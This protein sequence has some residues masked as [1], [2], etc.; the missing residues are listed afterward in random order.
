[1][2]SLQNDSFEL[3][4]DKNY[5]VYTVCR[6]NHFILNKMFEWILCC[7]ILLVVS[8]VLLVLLVL[9]FH[10]EELNHLNC[11]LWHELLRLYSIWNYIHC[12][13]SVIIVSP[14]LEFHVE[15][16]IKWMEWNGLNEMVNSVSAQLC[17]L[18]QPCDC[19]C[20][21]KYISTF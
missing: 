8:W 12:I 11:S 13:I 17:Y 18:C 15:S 16:W 19:D 1:M 6:F 5:W 20:Q 9:C 21:L 4:S 7:W 10:L 2:F 3:F 14:H